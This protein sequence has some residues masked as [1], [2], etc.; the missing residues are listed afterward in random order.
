MVEADHVPDFMQRQHADVLG[1]ERLAA[2]I[3][4]REG[5]DS[6]DHAPVLIPHHI[7]LPRALSFELG[8]PFEPHLGG[9]GVGV[10]VE[11]HGHAGL[12]PATEGVPHRVE[13]GRLKI[14]DHAGWEEHPYRRSDA[15]VP[16]VQHRVR[17]LGDDF[18]QIGEAGAGADPT[19][20]LGAR[21]EVEI[22]R[23]A[24]AAGWWLGGRRS[25]R[26]TGGTECVVTR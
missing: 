2:G 18:V 26:S 23:L 22:A 8:A 13:E 12:F 16:A 11:A 19:A 7:G 6:T 5:D 14:R 1:P 17:G 20:N 10:H 9:G 25:V 3:E 4:R 24:R 15:V 21:K